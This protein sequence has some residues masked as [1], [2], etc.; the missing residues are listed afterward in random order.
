[1][2]M[3]VLNQTIDLVPHHGLNNVRDHMVKINT[4]AAPLKRQIHRIFREL[5][6]NDQMPWL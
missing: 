1:M 2:K 4:D 5:Y 3:Q 6:Y